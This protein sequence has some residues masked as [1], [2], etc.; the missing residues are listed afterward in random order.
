M[1]K[2]RVAHVAHG[3]APHG[4][5]E[6]ER[7]QA[8]AALTDG[9]AVDVQQRLGQGGELAHDHHGHAELQARERQHSVPGAEHHVALGA[10]ET[11]LAVHVLAQERG[12]TQAL[13]PRLFASHD[14]HEVVRAALLLVALQ[15]RHPVATVHCVRGGRHGVHCC[16]ALECVLRF[17]SCVF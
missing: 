17:G 15:K 10:L 4:E 5:R 1:V 11:E 8:A 16:D 6:R 7:E 12:S 2:G 13:V 14:G 9:G 3:A